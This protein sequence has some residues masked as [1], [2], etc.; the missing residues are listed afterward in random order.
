[1]GFFGSVG[2]A[3]GGGVISDM[4]EKRA[5]AKVLGV[6]LLGPLL[7]PTIG[8]LLG[9]SIEGS[10]H[11]R[12]IFGVTGILA[13]VV[14][15]VCFFFLYETRAVTIL[16]QNKKR[17]ERENPGKKY[18]VEGTSEQGLSSKIASNSTR[19]V[20]ILVRQPI[21]STMSLY[22]ALVFSSMY[23]LYSQFT[24]IWSSPPYE[25]TKKQIGLTF[26]GP[27]LGFII[28]AVFI[29]LFIDRV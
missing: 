12:W 6:Y 21:V 28:C 10:T 24:T 5:R 16:E 4:M 20:K 29:V 17:L 14:T 26:L 23:S 25:F 19:A 9:G 18:V 27:A 11:W 7:G 13:G 15:L 22:Q 1:M 8:P 3:N 2:V